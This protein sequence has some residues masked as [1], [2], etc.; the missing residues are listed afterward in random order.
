[1]FSGGDYN[2]DNISAKDTVEIIQLSGYPMTTN[3][4]AVNIGSDVVVSWEIPDYSVITENFE[5]YDAF[6]DGPIGKWTLVDGD[7]LLTTTMDDLPYPNNGGKMS[8]M[9]FDYNS[10]PTSKDSYWYQPN[11]F[12]NKYLMCPSIDK[13]K[14]PGKTNNDWLISPLLSGKAQTVNFNVRSVIITEDDEDSQPCNYQ[15]LY[16]TTGTD[17]AD[18]NVL[19]ENTAQT[20]WSS[21]DAELPEGTNYFAIRNV[22]KDGGLFLVDDIA[23]EVNV[24]AMGYKILGFNVYRDY[25]MKRIAFISSAYNF[26][27]DLN[28]A[29]GDHRYYVTVMYTDG[30]SNYN[31]E[32]DIT[33]NTTGIKDNSQ[34]SAFYVKGMNNAITINNANNKVVVYTSGGSCI[35]SGMCKG[36]LTIPVENGLYIVKVGAK[37]FKITVK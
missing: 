13:K 1:L 37:V 28:V 19:K 26:Y 10:F 3:V 25:D 7:G 35:Y 29:E 14:N 20:S 6:T 17:T 4:K 11:I 30:E 31:Q 34:N 5:P 27:R 22:S 15:V 21:D 23:Y 24:K 33:I 16:S 12:G 9:V 18:F 36:N 8:Y 2:D 32:A